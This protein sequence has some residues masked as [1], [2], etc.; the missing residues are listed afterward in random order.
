MMARA[1]RE[2]GFVRTRAAFYT[3]GGEGD[4]GRDFSAGTM[5][6]L[7]R[8]ADEEDVPF[9]V[10]ENLED[11]VRFKT[12]RLLGWNPK[13]FINAGGGQAGLGSSGTPIPNGLLLPGEVRSRGLPEEG[14][15]I[16]EA[17][18]AGIPVLHMLEVR[19]LAEENGIPWDAGVFVKIKPGNRP[20]WA[21]AGLFLFFAVLYSYRRWLWDD[22]P[23]R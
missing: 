10:P 2:G 8:L 3:P 12:E 23:E 15:V 19:K 9:V 18:K 4:G 1:L 20:L 6:L 5:D 17:L 13:L 22:A 16:A 14:G 11:A 7:K 21:F